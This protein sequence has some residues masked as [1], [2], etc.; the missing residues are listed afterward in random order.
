MLFLLVSELGFAKSRHT[1]FYLSGADVTCL[2]PKIFTIVRGQLFC[3]LVSLA[4]VPWKLLSMSPSSPRPCDYILIL[5]QLMD[6]RS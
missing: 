2:Q 4:I 6:P 5:E 1:N 3:G